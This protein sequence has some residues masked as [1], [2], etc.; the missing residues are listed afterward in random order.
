M[1]LSYAALAALL[2]FL[3]ACAPQT[4]RLASP[5]QPRP[6]WAFEASDIP[7]EPGYRFG[8]LPSGMRYVIRSNANPQGTVAVRMEVA[9]GSLDETPS[10][11][12]FA[13]FVEHMA[14]NG[15]TNVP[16]GEM[17]RLLERNGLAFGAD[18]NASTS[19]QNTTYMLDLPRND[20]YLIETALMLMRETASE[21][22]FAPE[23]VERERGV[24][25]A[26]M[27]DRNSWQLRNG[28]A[29]AHF[30]HP[31]A[32]YPAR[33]PIGTTETLNAATAETLKA[34]WQREYVPSHTTLIVIGD[35]DV[36]AVEAA[37]TARFGN[38]RGGHAETQPDAGPVNDGDE[39][40][41]EI[42]IDPALSERII[43]SRHGSWIDGPDTVAQ[44]REEL[45]RQIGYGIVNR[46][47]QRISRQADPPFRAAGFGTGDVFRSGRT[48]NLVVDTIDG[49]WRR[50]LIAAVMEYRRALQYGFSKS[51]IAEQLANVEAAT[52]NAAASAETRTN[53]A[54]VNAVF[55]L[56]RD[57][58]VPSS[59]Q[60]SLARLEAF[61]PEITPER[62]LA[63]L[64]RES[65]PLND[66]LLRFQGRK[67]PVGGERAIRA[68]WSEA[69]RRKLAPGEA[70]TSAGFAYTDFGPPGTIAGDTRDTALGIRRIRFSNGV[71]LN[72][73]HTDIE[74]DRILLRVS[75]DGGEAIN[76]R[77]NPIATQM[78][79]YLPVGGL[80]RHSQDALQTILAG[81]T[82]GTGVSVGA[83]TFV[84]TA[85]TTPADLELQLQVFAA[86][87]TDPGYRPEGQVQ[88]RLNINNFFAQKDATPFSALQNGIGGILSANDPRFTLQNVEAYRKLTFDK[89]KTDLADRLAKGA[90]EIGVVGDVDEERTIALVAKTFG[91]LTAR[92]PDFKGNAGQPPRAFT[93]ERGRH[94]IR[95]GGPKDQALL[96]LTWPTRDDGDAID[97]LKLELLERILRIELTDTLREKLGK[98]YSP[99]ASSAPSRAWPGYGTFSI[100][101]SVDVHE[102]SATRAAIA[103]TLAELRDKPVSDDILLRA[104]APIIEG[105]DNA[106]KSNGGWLS[107]VD[108]AQ[109]EGERIDRYLTSRERML[110]LKPVDLQA[111]AQ[112][113]LTD[114]G[115]LEILV[116]PENV[117][118]PPE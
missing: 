108:R 37:I 48:T 99:S 62:V 61:L 52:R 101:A 75:V 72:L 107:L 106:L 9:A 14:F 114:A 112:R 110:A 16:E 88:Y 116:L 19:F 24:I 50:G 73:K 71:R 46:R 7:V 15:S 10:E 57:D 30:L 20:A 69:V 6:D 41:T 31:K 45:L 4:Q 86:F 33:F 11:L 39:D 26:E 8:K 76:T 60:S 67:V 89:L 64:K 83:G 103:E 70:E 78:V 36:T 58:V 1:R 32:L 90:I 65:V 115:A 5:S 84:S 79:P 96:R 93:T 13:H 28:I 82:V 55:G 35:V 23:A 21:L 87:I 77:D 74:R 3:S 100:A 66:P 109:T 68:A 97:T 47:M 56:L 91:A 95:H 42:Y 54:L 43:A 104:R 34:F 12:G 118:A 113:Y 17:I 81:R 102:V 29:Q 111:M 80:G 40:R 44:R 27:R 105:I 18:T 38:W 53:G 51:E 22:N 63:A 85:Q 92:E 98:A 117:P 49:R 25:L 59:P 2:A 94:I